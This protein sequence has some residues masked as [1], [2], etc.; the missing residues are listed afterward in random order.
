MSKGQKKFWYLW[1]FENVEA[2]NNSFSINHIIRGGAKLLPLRFS[3]FVLVLSLWKLAK[4]LW[5]CQS[6]AIVLMAEI[7]IIDLEALFFR[8]L[9]IPM[10]KISIFG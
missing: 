9:K 6:L 7:Q 2:G 1:Y 3:K 4:N 10:V 8:I 5:K